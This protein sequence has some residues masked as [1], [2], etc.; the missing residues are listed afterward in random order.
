MTA[1]LWLL[2]VTELANKITVIG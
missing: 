1:N 2:K